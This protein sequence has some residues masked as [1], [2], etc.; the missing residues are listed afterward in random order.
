LD[1]NLF[2]AKLVEKGMNIERLAAEI[3]LNPQTI[4]NKLKKDSFKMSEA[5]KIGEVLNLTSTELSHIFFA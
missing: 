1:T 4:Y 5:R 3:G 2:K